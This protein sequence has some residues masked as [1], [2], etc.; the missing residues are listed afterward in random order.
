MVTLLSFCKFF[1]GTATAT[2]KATTA[3]RVIP[4]LLPPGATVTAHCPQSSAGG[5]VCTAWSHSFKKSYA[6]AFRVQHEHRSSM[7]EIG[8]SYVCLISMQCREVTI[9]PSQTPKRHS[10]SHNNRNNDSCSH[11]AASP[12]RQ[13]EGTPSTEQQD[14]MNH[15]PKE[16]SNAQLH[17]KPTRR[18]CAIPRYSEAARFQ[19]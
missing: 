13:S 7:R 11:R 17:S 9:F 6:M 5:V 4:Q 18:V 2:A 10:S 8:I 12:R 15:A 3:A 19:S 1:T 14:D 16:T